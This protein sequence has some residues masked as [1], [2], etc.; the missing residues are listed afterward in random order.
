MSSIIEYLDE[1]KIWRKFYHSEIM[2]LVRTF[3]KTW[4]RVNLEVPYGRAF[5]IPVCAFQKDWCLPLDLSWD[6]MLLNFDIRDEDRNVKW[7]WNLYHD[8][9]APYPAA[10]QIAILDLIEWNDLK[11]G[12]TFFNFWCTSWWERFEPTV[13]RWW[14]CCYEINVNDRIN[15]CLY[16]IQY[17]TIKFYDPL[18][19]SC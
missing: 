2:S 18:D 15:K 10:S 6:E 16:T 4:W 19:C 11:K 8:W 3:D 13:P 7:I 14:T 12:K 5:C 17:W 1:K 9:V